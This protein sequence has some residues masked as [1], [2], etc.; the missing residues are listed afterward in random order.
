MSHEGHG[1]SGVLIVRSALMSKKQ[2]NDALKEMQE[3]SMFK[4]LT[5]YIMA[6]H[7]GS[8]FQD[9]LDKNGPG[10]LFQII[11]MFPSLSIRSY[12]CQSI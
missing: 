9:Q 1:D 4:E 6:C 3:K 8:M 7:G 2:L 12:C 11:L 10:N 5:Y